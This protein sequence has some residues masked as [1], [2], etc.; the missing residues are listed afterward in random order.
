MQSI[1]VVGVDKRI[2]GKAQVRVFT[3]RNTEKR[4][5]KVHCKLRCISM[6]HLGD[7]N[8]KKWNE[9]LHFG[10]ADLPTSH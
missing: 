10:R 3:M 2:W 7:K 9:N 8:W 1:G 5:N 4:R 6:V